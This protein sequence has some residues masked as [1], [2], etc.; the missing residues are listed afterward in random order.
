M[1][2]KKVTGTLGFSEEKF[3]MSKKNLPLRRRNS[4]SEII[5]YRLPVFHG[6]GKK[7][8][9]DFYAYDPMRG[10]LRRKKIHLDHISTKVA[11]RR[12]AH[13]L[14]S[15]LTEKLLS[16]WNPWCDAATSR[17]F[18]PIETII[19]KYKEYV[20]RTGRK[21]TQQCYNSRCNILEEYNSTRL[22][23]IRYAY[24][25]DKAFVIDF[26]DWVLLDRD[27]GARTCNNYKGWCSAFGE[28]M[29]QRKY[30]DSNPAEGIPKLPEDSKFRQPLTEQMM[31]K[32]HRHLKQEDPHFLLAVMMEYFTFIRP[33]ELSNLRLRDIEIKRAAR[34]H[35]ER[36]QQKQARWICR[37]K[38]DDHPDD[39]RS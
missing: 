35:I 30:I 2:E 21:K 32:L 5:G 13:V 7:V 34:I 26:L 19:E 23:P 29:V 9:V 27:S 38:R 20:G 17:G 28:F 22:Q 25:Y 36:I 3:D 39:D 1:R 8:Y 18:T 4:D 15:T 37:I 31:R 10:E 33:T 11:Q 6:T 12:H 14:I 16:G 24:Q